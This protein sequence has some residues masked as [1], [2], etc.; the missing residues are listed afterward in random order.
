MKTTDLIDK[1]KNENCFLKFQNGCLKEAIV[2][3]QKERDELK[4]KLKANS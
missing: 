2:M 4:E 3:L 1:I